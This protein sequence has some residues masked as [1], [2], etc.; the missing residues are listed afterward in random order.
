MGEDIDGPMVFPDS[1]AENVV[2]MESFVHAK[3]RFFMASPRESA[4]GER[5]APGWPLAGC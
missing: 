5:P 1:A 4:T 3:E 2:G